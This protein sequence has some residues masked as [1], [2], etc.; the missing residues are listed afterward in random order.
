M[1]QTL[2][3]NPEDL[4]KIFS[5]H[6][7]PQSDVLVSIYKLI[8]PDWDKIKSI[9]SPEHTWPQCNKFTWG[10]I[11]RMFQNFDDLQNRKRPF[12]KEVMP[13]G[14]WLNSGFSSTDKSCEELADWEVRLCPVT[15]YEKEAA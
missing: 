4:K 14:A 3:L 12:D 15:Y 1:S 13:G 11:C 10:E 5:R 2:K 9:G 8:F 6:D 7:D